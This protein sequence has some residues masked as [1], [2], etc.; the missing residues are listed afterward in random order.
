MIRPHRL[1]LFLSIAAVAAAC[2][3][4]KLDAAKAERQIATGVYQ[5]LGVKVDIDCPEDRPLEKGD[6]F[7]C[8][9]ASEDA[10]NIV[11][12]ARQTNS[13]GNVRWS[14]KVL[15]T[16]RYEESIAQDIYSQRRIKVTLD[17]PD[18]VSSAKGTEFTCEAREPKSGQRQD[19]N[20]EVT[21][22]K[23]N[24]KFSS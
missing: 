13:K 16:E 24:I 14:A 2:G 8:T 21:D 20:V 18:L 5:Q 19:I 12:R 10:D 11:V 4:G 23:G 1:A 15:A 9:L 7:S 6:R 22:S 3:A 17:C